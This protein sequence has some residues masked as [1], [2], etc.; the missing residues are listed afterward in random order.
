V[1]PSDRAVARNS[2]APVPYTTLIT[3]PAGAW[4]AGGLVRVTICPTR[5]CTPTTRNPSLCSS[6]EAAVNFMPTTSGTGTRDGV[7]EAEELAEG[8]AEGLAVGLPVGDAERELVAGEPAG[9]TEW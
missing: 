3:L 2:R 6:S 4:P 8:L 9:D 7:P 1:L 5:M